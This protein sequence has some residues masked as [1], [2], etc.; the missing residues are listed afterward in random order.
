ML[1]CLYVGM[2]VCYVFVT[3]VTKVEAKGGTKMDRA[4]EATLGG[5][6]GS[7]PALR[8][9]VVGAYVRTRVRMLQLMYNP[10]YP[11]T[12]HPQI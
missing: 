4:E 12:N 11:P 5:D 1:A 7:P 8:S 9:L 3:E 2:F 10:V 6:L